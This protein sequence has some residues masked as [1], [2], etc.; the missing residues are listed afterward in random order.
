M[1][2]D[3]DK[4]ALELAIKNLKD[5]DKA[6]KTLSISFIIALVL[7]SLA[8]VLVGFM[9]TRSIERVVNL[10]KDTAIETSDVTIDYGDGEFNGNINQGDDS[11]NGKN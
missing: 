6:Y 1:D 4:L 11:F 5:R 10:L 3:Y 2:K 7:I 8:F 9:N